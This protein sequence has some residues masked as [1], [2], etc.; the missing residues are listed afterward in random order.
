MEKQI[1]QNLRE[2]RISHGLKPMNVSLSLNIDES[3]IYKIEGGTLKSWGKYIRPTR[4]LR[5][6]NG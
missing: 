5:Q 1:G 4:A 3:T 6:A 2:L